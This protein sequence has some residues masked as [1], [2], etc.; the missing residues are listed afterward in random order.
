MSVT[1]LCSGLEGQRVRESERMTERDIEIEREREKK[2][3]RHGEIMPV[4]YGNNVK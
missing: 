3:V 4:R 1:D 2:S